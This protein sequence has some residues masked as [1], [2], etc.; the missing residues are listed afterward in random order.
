MWESL[1]LAIFNS[2][3]LN[4]TVQVLGTDLRTFLFQGKFGE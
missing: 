3:L 1:N 2:R 4:A